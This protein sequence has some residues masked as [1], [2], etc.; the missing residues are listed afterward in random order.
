MSSPILVDSPIDTSGPMSQ[1]RPGET[2]SACT[3]R[4]TQTD[5]QTGRKEGRHL[6]RERKTGREGRQREKQRKENFERDGEE[7]ML[8]W[9]FEMVCLPTRRKERQQK[10]DDLASKP[11]RDGGM[12]EIRE[13]ERNEDEDGEREVTRGKTRVE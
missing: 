3:D 7:E 2:E 13:R 11:C 9:R 6:A 4:D 12:G 1:R 8:E 10:E 5:R